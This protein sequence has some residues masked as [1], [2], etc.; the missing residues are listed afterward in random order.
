MCWR[1]H[2]MFSSCCDGCVVTLQGYEMCWLA[3]GGGCDVA[4]E[5]SLNT[6]W[7]KNFPFQKALDLLLD[8]KNSTPE[9][10]EA[11]PKQTTR[12]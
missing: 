7:L 2:A 8:L 10:T 9:I 6:N 12:P 5:V 1:A 4:A 3:E 11:N